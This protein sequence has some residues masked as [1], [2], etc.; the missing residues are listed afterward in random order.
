MNSEILEKD[1]IKNNANNILQNEDRYFYIM[2]SGDKIK[3]LSSSR[4][5]S[6]A[7]D[8]TLNFL[9]T[10]LDKLSN[11]ETL[12]VIYRFNIK[13]FSKLEKEEYKSNNISSSGGSVIIILEEVTITIKNNK[14]KLKI[15]NNIDGSNKIFIDNK[16]L[17][18]YNRVNKNILKNISKK[19]FSTQINSFSVNKLSHFII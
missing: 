1:L 4:N 14:I 5:K 19:Y 10:K 17:K 2:I 18:K 8:E 9:Y 13:K 11:S 7:H 15:N 12:P 3:I 6:D 16:Y